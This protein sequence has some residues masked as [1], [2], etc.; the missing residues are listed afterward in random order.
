[1]LLD[2]R[3]C[4]TVRVWDARG[5][6]A[7]QPHCNQN[8]PCVRTQV[9]SDY[10]TAYDGESLFL[11]SRGSPVVEY[12]YKMSFMRKPTAAASLAPAA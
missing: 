4:L 12:K 11:E 2:C 1:M 5:P 6:G 9:V 3:W 8:C 10:L 7:W